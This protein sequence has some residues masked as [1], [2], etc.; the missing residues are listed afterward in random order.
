MNYFFFNWLLADFD[1]L[2]FIEARFTISN[3]TD[4][5]GN[6]F[7]HR[8]R[9]VSLVKHQTT[10]KALNSS[11]TAVVVRYVGFKSRDESK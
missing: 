11:A 4:W 10:L 6:S 5:K 2:P 7:P 1:I 8:Q 9:L 3:N